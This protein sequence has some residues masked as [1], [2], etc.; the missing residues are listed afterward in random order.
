[1]SATVMI[2]DVSHSPAALVA[3]R[4]RARDEVH[5]IIAPEGATIAPRSLARGASMALLIL[6]VFL[7][8]A[9]LVAGLLLGSAMLAVGTFFGFSLMTLIGMPLILA[10]VQEATERA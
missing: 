8:G 5:V 9:S 1:M 4:A 2:A 3:D 6:G 10:C 7:V